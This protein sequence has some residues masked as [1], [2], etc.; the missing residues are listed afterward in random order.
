MNWNR[1]GC[2]NEF[3]CFISI[4]AFMHS[5]VSVCMFLVLLLIICV[6]SVYFHSFKLFF[7]MDFTRAD[8]VQDAHALAMYKVERDWFFCHCL[9]MSGHHLHVSRAVN[10]ANAIDKIICLMVI[11]FKRLTHSFTQTCTQHSH[12]LGK[13]RRDKFVCDHCG[14]L[15]HLKW[16]D[17]PC[18]CEKSGRWTLTNGKA[19]VC[20]C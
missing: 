20:V 16:I 14:L 15:M 9:M 13:S 7:Q 12:M 1:I 17:P 4:H 11:V 19:R 2:A 18:S 8:H 3:K 10:E 6:F 5:C